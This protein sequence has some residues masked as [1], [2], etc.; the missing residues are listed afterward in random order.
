MKRKFPKIITQESKLPKII[1]KEEKKP[2][3]KIPT[4][5]RWCEYFPGRLPYPIECHYGRTFPYV[6]ERPNCRTCERSV[7]YTAWKSGVWRR[8]IEEIKKGI[9]LRD[10]PSPFQKDY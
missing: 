3:R 6:A 4:V 10:Q 8:V 7:E 1:P 5:G 2:L 9:D